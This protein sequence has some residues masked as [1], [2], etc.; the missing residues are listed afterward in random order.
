MTKFAFIFPA[1]VVF[2]ESNNQPRKV[3]SEFPLYSFDNQNVYFCTKKGKVVH[4]K[5]QFNCYFLLINNCLFYF[6]TDFSDTSAISRLDDLGERYEAALKKYSDYVDNPVIYEQEQAA[7]RERWRQEKE[8]RDR[9]DEERKRQRAI[10]AENAYRA[11]IDKFKAGEYLDWS[12]FERACKE[13]EIT[14]PIKTIGWG[15]KYV[16]SVSLNSYR[17]SGKNGSTI[18]GRIIREL[19]SRLT[20]G[21]VGV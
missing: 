13:N 12:Y 18:L 2:A 7:N 8:Q 20:E 14:I 16:T 10:N 1:K 21:N 3:D 15:R 11:A 9:E 5:E 17:F 19:N 4:K 6:R